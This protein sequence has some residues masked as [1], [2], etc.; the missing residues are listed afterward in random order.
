MATYRKFVDKTPAQFHGQKVLH[1]HSADDLRELGRVAKCVWQPE[2]QT[3][4]YNNIDDNHENNH[5]KTGKYAEKTKRKSRI[6]MFT[7]K[8]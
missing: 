6:S 5:H 1:S 4:N 8:K 2:L 7:A 3:H